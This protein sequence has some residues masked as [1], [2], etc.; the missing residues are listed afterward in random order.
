MAVAQK[1]KNILL[2]VW[3]IISETQC[4]GPIAWAFVLLMQENY[5]KKLLDKYV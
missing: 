5:G 3:E 1:V 4:R 2:S